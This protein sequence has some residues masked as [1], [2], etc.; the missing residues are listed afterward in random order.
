MPIM[1]NMNLITV[2]F[3]TYP[4]PLEVQST[5]KPVEGLE[6]LQTVSSTSIKIHSDNNC[7][8]YL[9]DRHYQVMS[10]L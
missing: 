5:G 6:V 2:H 10:L 3:W 1:R 8:E 9:S 7:W 4:P